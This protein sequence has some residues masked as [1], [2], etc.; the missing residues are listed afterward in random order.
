[1][2]S[3]NKNIQLLL[4]IRVCRTV[5]LSQAAS[6]EPFVHR[7]N[8]ANVGIFYRYYYSRCSSELAQLVPLPYSGGRSTRYSNRLHDFS[9]IIP[10]YYKDV[11]VISFF[12]HTTR[13]SNFLS[14]ECFPLT[15]DLN[16]FKFRINRHP[17]T[18]GPF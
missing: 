2:R 5:G 3:L 14:V 6:L 9:V 4:G 18:V 13:L 15:F 10:R 16:G 17:L 11:Y 8:V 7:R 1:M 12:P